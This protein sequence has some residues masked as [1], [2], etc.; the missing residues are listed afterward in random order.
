MR[1]IMQL[2]DRVNEYVDANKPWELAK[3]EGMDAQHGAGRVAVLEGLDNGL[4]LAAQLGQQGLA[5]FADRAQLAV[6]A[7]GDEAGR[8][9]GNVHVLADQVRPPR[10]AC[11]AS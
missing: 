6:E 1:E 10:S 2:C 7:L 5:V 11:T 4:A 8:A 3:Q 9:R